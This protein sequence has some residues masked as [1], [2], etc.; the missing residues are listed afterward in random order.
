MNNLKNTL[1]NAH[2]DFDELFYEN[3]EKYSASLKQWNRTHN[4]TGACEDADI[5]KNIID[6]VY[7]L[8]FISTPSRLVDIGTGAGYP[9][10][11]LAMAMRDTYCIL[12]EPRAKRVAFLNYVKNLLKL[13]NVEIVQDRI[14]NIDLDKIDLITSRAVSNT[15]FLMELTQHIHSKSTQYL[16]YKGSLLAN[17]LEDLKI[18]HE[19]YDVV[20]VDERNYLYIKKGSHDI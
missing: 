15:K 18:K 19:D 11:I 5:E 12:V 10:L 17:E 14:E 7:P 16:F 13:D 20:N 9:G 4:L 6:S 3:C 2:L 8:T 1:K